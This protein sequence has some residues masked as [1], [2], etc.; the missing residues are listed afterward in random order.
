M[1]FILLF[2]LILA[3]AAT[4]AQYGTKVYGVLYRIDWAKDKIYKQ[5]SAFVIEGV[6]APTG[7]PA[8]KYFSAKGERL[9][10]IN[11]AAFRPYKKKLRKK[12]GCESTAMFHFPIVEK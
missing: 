4:N 1:K 6:F 2:A 7:E 9:D 8:N 12:Y 10:D 5:D 11:V 3:Y